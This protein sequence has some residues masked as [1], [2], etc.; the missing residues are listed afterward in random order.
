M[1]AKFLIAGDT[2]VSIQL[3]SEISL[4]V[5]QLVRT[6]L[7]EL[8]E[9]PVEGIVE[10]VPTYASLM[11]HYRPEVIRYEQLQEEIKKRIGNLNPV[12]GE[13]RV[14]K[15]LPI[16]YGGEQGPDLEECAA[17]ENVSTEELIRMHSE[18]EYYTYMLGFAPGHAYKARFAEPFHFKRRESP[19]I[20]ISARSI[21]VMENLSNL[22]PFEQPSGWN[23][24]ASTPLEVCDYTREDP[25]LVHAGEWVRYVP[26]SRREYDRIREDVRKGTYRIK[27]HEKVVT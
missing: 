18:H 25:F 22:I 24:I 8:E 26:V 27:T 5:N 20:R 6:L 11:V 1:K 9:H 3:G 21:V 7:M 12:Q 23:I 16:C 19:R 15:E 17:Y 2:A 10:M 13:K 4:E 14:V